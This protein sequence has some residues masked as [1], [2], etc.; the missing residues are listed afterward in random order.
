M[1]EFLALAVE[2]VENEVAVLLIIMVVFALSLHKTC[3]L[4]CVQMKYTIVTSKPKKA[5]SF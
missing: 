1:G 5:F 4:I 3:S 2:V